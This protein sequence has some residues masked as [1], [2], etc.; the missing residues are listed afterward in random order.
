MYTEEEE[1]KETRIRY[2]AMYQMVKGGQGF[3]QMIGGTP[4]LEVEIIRR[5]LSCDGD[6][7]LACV[8]CNEFNYYTRSDILPV[9]RGR[10]TLFETVPFN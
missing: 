3:I 1:I 2:L 7:E 6:D 9:L 4:S 8:Q 5:S 10:K